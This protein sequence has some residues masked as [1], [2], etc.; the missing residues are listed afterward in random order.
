VYPKI[1]A[2]SWFTLV[3][4]GAVELHRVATTRQISRAAYGLSGKLTRLIP[5]ADETLGLSDLRNTAV[6]GQS[7]E[8]ALAD[9]PLLYPLFGTQ[10]PL[11]SVQIL[12]APAQSLAFR[13]QRQR[14]TAPEDPR[15]VSFPD[16][17]T[18][19]ALPG[20]SFIVT[21]PPVALVGTD[22]QAITP[23]DLDPESGFAERLRW[24]LLDRDG[25]TVIVEADAGVLQLQAAH[26]DD[27]VV[28]EVAAIDVGPDAI[29]HDRDRTS[30]R[31]AAALANCYDR[32]T[33]RVNA[34]VAPATHGETVGE[35]AGAG[36]ASA[37]SQRFRL[38]QSPLTYV[39]ASNPQG[40]VST[41][42]VRVNDLLWA[43]VPTLYNQPATAH[44]YALRQDDEART[45]VQFG[46]GIEG[47]RLPS[48]SDNVRMGYRKGLGV[49]GN[50]RSGTVTT[51]LSRPLGVKSATNP[52]AAAGG[53]DPEVLADARR[54][55]PITVLTLDRAVSIL[56]YA[57]FARA[58]AGISK[59]MAMW[60][61]GGVSRG[62]HLTV[63]G[64][65][66]AAVQEGGFT[67]Q[68]LL[69]ALRAYGDALLPLTL[70]S[71]ASA[72]FEL[73]ARIKIDPLYVAEDVLADV[74]SALR[75]AYAFDAR[76]FGQP[77][78]FDEVLATTHGVAG[79]VA[80]D[81]NR[82]HRSG[83][84]PNPR[85]EPRLFPA[86]ALIQPDGSVSAAELLTLADDGL[87]LSQMP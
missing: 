21:Q 77:V 13:G 84:A 47:A 10:V 23:A 35:I 69:D 63:A 31:L 46:D 75:T 11:A 7:E 70:Q 14:V 53:E 60:I 72:T 45:I 25:M 57:D 15:D 58:F 64:I 50:V 79:V 55:A 34:N 39:A 61:G 24:T 36:D 9:R 71:Y 83:V 85:P 40:R 8:L 87:L 30:V 4:G 52:E 49:A 80:V 48:G 20:E 16:D 43:E 37:A 54:N 74:E 62:V 19:K 73:E 81:V 59:S 29:G 3:D 68:A 56:D 22:T 32:S 26:E 33:V 1:V 41:L 44:V 78:T 65:G 86:P 12:L 27:L 6:F 17:A 67:H 38:R 82:L 5:P 18:R 2:G 28:E 76:D 42:S 51:L 66:G